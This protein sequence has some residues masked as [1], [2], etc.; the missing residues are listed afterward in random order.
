MTRPRRARAQ[1]VMV[2]MLDE[3]AQ[4]TIDGG[5]EPWTETPPPANYREQFPELFARTERTNP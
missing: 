1:Q 4:L 2:E 3:P 5:A